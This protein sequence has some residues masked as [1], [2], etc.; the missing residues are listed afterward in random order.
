MVFGK[1]SAS[2]LALAIAVP[3]VPAVMFLGTSHSSLLPGTTAGA[4][5][6][7]IPVHGDIS[8][9]GRIQGESSW[10][11]ASPGNRVVC[12]GEMAM[13]LLNPRPRRVNWNAALYGKHALAVLTGSGDALSGTGCHYRVFPIRAAFRET[14]SACLTIR[15][16][17]KAGSRRQISLAVARWQPG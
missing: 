15:F 8:Y 7:V 17:G 1:V 2:G 13:W 10:W 9:P 16:P 6:Q 11:H 14:R 5:S 12:S 3:L 4:S